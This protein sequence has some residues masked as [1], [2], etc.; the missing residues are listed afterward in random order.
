MQHDVDTGPTPRVNKK[1]LSLHK[2]QTVRLVGEVKA[3]Q[4]A[5][6]VVIASDKGEVNVHANHSSSDL[7][8][9]QIVE[10][11]VTVNNDLS[12]TEQSST[13]FPYNFS[14]YNIIFLQLFKIVLSTYVFFRQGELRSAGEFYCPV[15]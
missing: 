12:V 13:S 14:T 8:A 10:I 9:G 15:P 1:L 2:G 11:V 6:M 7:Q 5:R 4:G 3:I